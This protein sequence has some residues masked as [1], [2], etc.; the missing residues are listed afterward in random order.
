MKKTIIIN[1]DTYKK[2]QAALLLTGENEENALDG[3]ICEYAR[4][5]FA[6]V[7]GSRMAESDNCRQGSPEGVSM[8]ANKESAAIKQ[9]QRFTGWFR[10]LSRNGKAYNPVTIS[11]Y[12]GR[13]EKACND[14]VFA[15]IQV[16]NLFEITE[17]SEFVRIQAQIKACDGYAEFD[18][19]SHNGFTAALKKYEEFL[20]NQLSEHVVQ[21]SVM[22]VYQPSGIHR[23][24]EAEDAVCCRRFLEYYVL[25]R[26]NLDM[27]SF[28]RMLS[29]EVPAV[30]EGS[31]RMKIQNIRHLA[32]QAGIKDTSGFAPLSQYSAQ[33]ARIFNQIWCEIG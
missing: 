11:G 9:K 25:Q 27:N 16:R 13:I 26:S 5:A 23:W 6:N 12:A 28:V 8:G 15:E 30:S 32:M 17:L 10:S 33:C 18:S 24:T 22:P 29:K 21:E 3:M 20:Q 4:K 2:L 1:E 7:M 14:P 31:L 19:R